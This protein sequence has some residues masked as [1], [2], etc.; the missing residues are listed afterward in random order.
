MQE[1]MNLIDRLHISPKIGRVPYS[2][3]MKQLWQLYGTLITRL[4]A[5]KSILNAIN[6]FFVSVAGDLEPLRP[7]FLAQ[8]TDDYSSKFII[9]VAEVCLLYTS[10]AADE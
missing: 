1:S 7:E 2:S 6:E 9:E 10:D 8:L 3:G 5:D 4:K